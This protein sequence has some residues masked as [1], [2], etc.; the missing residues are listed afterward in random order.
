MKLLKL[1]DAKRGFTLIELLVVIV[2]ISVLATLLM[3]NFVGV[4]ARGRDTTRKSDL[5]QL[6]VALELYRSDVGTY[7]PSLAACG[8]P[9]ISGG[10]TYIAKVPCDPLGTSMTYNS[11]VYYYNSPAGNAT[12]TLGACIENSNDSD[13]NTT[14]TSP[15][16]TG[17]CTAGKYFVLI[18]P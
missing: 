3:V 15:G 2:I 10:T 8:T 9:V 11:G 5:R 14:S 1:H 13:S 7:P 18:N 12:Y 6:Q 4:R 17:A 16:G